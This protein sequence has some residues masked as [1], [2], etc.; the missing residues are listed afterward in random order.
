MARAL[1]SGEREQLRS[2]A[3]RAAGGL[4]LFGFHW[5]AWQSRQISLRVR[6]ADV[7]ELDQDIERLRE[8]L[9]AVQVE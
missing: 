2:M 8:H 4:A 9:Q 3:H 6:H 7:V 5:A 1:A